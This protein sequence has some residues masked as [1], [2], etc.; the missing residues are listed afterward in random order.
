MHLQ[1]N[2]VRSDQKVYRYVRLVQSYRR[3]DGLPMK[4]VVA[5]LGALEEP[6]I[7]A[8]KTALQAARTGNAVV[9]A[10][11]VGAQMVALSVA[12]SLPYLD[13]AVLWALWNGLG[14]RTLLAHVLP[15][16]RQEVSSADVVFALVAQ[17]CMT[18]GGVARSSPGAGHSAP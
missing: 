14:L 13:V 1:I 18:P 3:D 5:N 7:A 2:Q 15:V 4:K 6:V 10:E 11:E 8:R 17:R 9:I 12:Q 16:G